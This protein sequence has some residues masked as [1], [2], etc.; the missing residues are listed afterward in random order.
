M[1]IFLYDSFYYVRS[2]IRNLVF[3]NNTFIVFGRL[4]FIVTT[5]IHYRTY[6]PVYFHPQTSVFVVSW[7]T[8]LLGVPCANTRG[9][10]ESHLDAGTLM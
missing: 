6:T 2:F 1:H 4:M 10:Y 3:L 8:F 7:T 9:S 5:T